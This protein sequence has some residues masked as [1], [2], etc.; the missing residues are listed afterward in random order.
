MYQNKWIQKFLKNIAFSAMILSPAAELAA[1]ELSP[2]RQIEV[3]IIR[4]E[5]LPLLLG[6]PFENYSVMVVSGVELTPIPYQFD[7]RNER[8]FLYA[9]GGTLKIKGTEGIFEEE[10]ELA[11]MLH[12]TGD[13]ASSEQLDGLAGKLINEIEIDLGTTKRYAYLVEGNTARSDVTYTHFNRETGLIKTKAY[14]LQ[15]DPDNLLVWSDYFYE[16]YSGNESILDSMKLRIHG[17]LGFLKAT[18]SNRLIPSDI[19]AVKN[20]PV[21]TLIEMDASVGMLG[22]KAL[23]LGA[24]AVMT[25]NTTEFPVYLTVPKAAGVLSALDI[26]ISLDLNDMEKSRYRTELG[27]KEPVIQGGGGA[28]PKDLKIDLDNNWLSASSNKNWDII[29]F[30]SHNEDIRVDLNVLY[31]DTSIGDKPDKPERFKGSYSQMGYTVADI[32]TNIA[33]TIG[34]NLYYGNDL[35]QGNNVEKAVHEIRN[36]APITINPI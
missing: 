6:K 33:S 20:G 28:D 23:E 30:F 12:D 11:F 24:S 29:A 27:P 25:E 32:P 2:A 34:I 15:V 3:S 10:D 31:K 5:S 19:V 17:R 18:A 8:G 9:P 16:G 13:R 14:S 36:P 1:E 7:E 35:W 21:R 4:G 26:D 22:I